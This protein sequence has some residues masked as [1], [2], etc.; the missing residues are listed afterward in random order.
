MVSLSNHE[1]LAALLLIAVTAVVVVVRADDPVSS[2]VRYTGEIV[3]IFDRKCTPCH[4]D[5]SLAMP[6]ASYRQVR[7]W[8]R[9]IR[10]EIVEQRMPPWSA[11]RG[12]QRFRNELALSAREATTVLTWLDGGMPRGD[13]KDLPGPVALAPDDPPDLHL[14]VP[15]QRVPAGEEHVVRRIAI[16]AG[17]AADRAVARFVVKP[18][19]RSVLRGALLFAGNDRDG[20]RWVGAWLPWQPQVAPPAPH[21]F[22]LPARGGMTLELHYRGSEREVL[23]QPSVDVYFARA[24]AATTE[25]DVAAGPPARLA[26]A[27]RIWAIVPSADASTRSLEVIAR[28]P[29]GAM[30][31][32]LWIPEYRHEWPQALV[33]DDP[34][35]L[36]A[37]TIVTTVAEPGTSAARVRLSLLPAPG[38]AAV[39]GV[40]RPT[41]PQ[42]EP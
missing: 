18:G 38:R 12:Y 2:N 23:D 32:L 17:A 35:S 26:S 10:E 39:K 11:A 4:G 37:G 41:R 1:R 13:D 25:L 6:L 28:R 3:R 36:P 24:G 33:L 5:E 29:N 22:L 8:G 20:D 40:A 7:D 34:I 27:G 9:A 30:D 15:A 21:A 16:D 42:A 19:V 31:V 14:A